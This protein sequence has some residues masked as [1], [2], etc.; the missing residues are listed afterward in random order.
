MNR[1]SKVTIDISD[2]FTARSSAT[3]QSNYHTILSWGI[4]MS[5]RGISTEIREFGFISVDGGKMTELGSIAKFVRKL[6]R[7]M[8]STG[9]AHRTRKSLIHCEPTSGPEVPPLAVE[10]LPHLAVIMGSYR[11]K[12]HRLDSS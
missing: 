6:S 9:L 5:G 10:L 12:C 3:P 8:Y 11:G 2:H 1:D 4:G 7:L